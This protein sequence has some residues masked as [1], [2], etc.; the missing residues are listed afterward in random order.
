MIAVLVLAF[1]MAP[2]A[3]SLSIGLH[4]LLDDHHAAADSATESHDHEVSA[5]PDHLHAIVPT[6][7]SAPSRI[8][9]AAVLAPEITPA[10][11]SDSWRLPPQTFAHSPPSTALFLSHCALLI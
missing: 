1:W 3:V 8:V 4:L 6:R 2:A 9:V 10:R 11:H 5:S 7:V